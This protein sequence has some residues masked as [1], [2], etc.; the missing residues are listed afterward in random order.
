ME[1]LVNLRGIG[2][3]GNVY[4]YSHTAVTAPGVLHELQRF[5]KRERDERMTILTNGPANLT[6]ERVGGN[7]Y[8][9]FVRSNDGERIVVLSDLLVSKVR[10]YHYIAEKEGVGP[11]LAEFFANEIG[12]SALCIST[13]YIST[14]RGCGISIR[15]EE[16]SF[17]FSVS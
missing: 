12:I 4:G 7:I 6:I 16:N 1:T 11:T 15:R 9:T 10:T 2:L 14:S 8:L 3:I 13:L 5:F 17:Y